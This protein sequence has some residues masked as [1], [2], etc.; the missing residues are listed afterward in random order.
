MKKHS[1]ISILILIFCLTAS[2][3]FAQDATPAAGGGALTYTIPANGEISNDTFSQIWTLETASADRITIHVE[4][5]GG[6]LIPDVSL[7]DSNSQQI[8]T[9]YGSDY[10]YATAEIA[11]YTLPAGGSY[12]ILVQ[13]KDG[14]T[15]VTT[16]TYSIVVTPVATAEDNPNNTASVGEITAGTPVSGEITGAHW[17]QRYVF[18][19][20][21][22]DVIQLSA[23]RT[24]GSLFPQIEVLDANGSNLNTGYTDY[25][26][27]SA[28]IN[29]V[30]LPGAG[31]FTIAVTRSS[32]FSGYTVGTYEL[33]LSIIGA[34]EDNPMLA[35][36]MGDAAYDT[37]LQ[38]DIGA[39]WYE[40]WTLVTQAGDTISIDATRSSGNLQPEVILLGG[41]NQELT[42]GYTNRTGDGATIDRY[43]L[44]GP[45]T[46]TVRVS[47]SSGKT[48]VSTGGYTLMV[49]LDGAGEGSTTLQ[50]A[51]GEL[52]ES[53][54]TD[55]TITA[56]RW[57]DT[58]TFTGKKGVVMDIVAERKEGTLI[59]HVEIRDSNGQTLNSAYPDASQDRAEIS[60]YALP[61]DGQY[62]IVVYRD[63]EQGGYTVG[64]YTVT[65]KP[66]GS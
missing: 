28:E 44:N 36:T 20:Q 8:T 51:T 3:A 26:G 43:Q 12:Q 30:Q 17:Y 4:R 45:G 13:R 16:G 32:G 40:D 60:G 33:N 65:V 29:Q 21:G 52:Q 66:T 31:A 62:Q 34:G 22:A 49:S 9:S 53:T 54:P 61:G 57:A 56:A 48:G 7:L 23:K 25:S 5:T 38:G 39:R 2:V 18:N 19:A 15:G 11:D 42:H 50:G 1:L 41:S 55:G 10:T 58:W 24:G 59:P 46:Y 27:D 63:G 6:N 14:G 47:R 35:G 64:T 37:A